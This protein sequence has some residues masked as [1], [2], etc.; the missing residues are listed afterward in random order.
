MGR[1]KLGN[2]T[3]KQGEFIP[4]EEIAS[5]LAGYTFQG[6]GLL[7]VEES[8]SLTAVLPWDTWCDNFW[9]RCCDPS[10]SLMISGVGSGERK[11]IYYLF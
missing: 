2:N 6:L 8:K 3:R 1:K 9:M 10:D 4:T 7:C 5:I 11:M